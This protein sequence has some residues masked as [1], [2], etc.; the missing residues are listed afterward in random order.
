MIFTNKHQD[1]H[2]L[3]RCHCSRLAAQAGWSIN[4][5]ET[6]SQMPEASA[7][8][9]QVSPHPL[10]D[11][12]PLLACWHQELDHSRGGFP[13]PEEE[14]APR[15]DEGPNGYDPQPGAG[16]WDFFSLARQR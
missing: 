2:C 11:F 16:M 1:R 7:S 5:T 13:G 10:W 6:Q 12:T 8:H 15:V 14:T 3:E 4:G 9:I